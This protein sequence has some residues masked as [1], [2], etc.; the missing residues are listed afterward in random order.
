[1]CFSAVNRKQT[2]SDRSFS[3]DEAKSEKKRFVEALNTAPTNPAKNSQY[4]QEPKIRKNEFHKNHLWGGEA[5]LPENR[6]A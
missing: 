6:R 1:Q 3:S 5:L 2:S 4:S